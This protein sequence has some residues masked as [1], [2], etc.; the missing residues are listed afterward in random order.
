MIPE[1]YDRIAL[2]DWMMEVLAYRVWRRARGETLFGCS[3]P[4]SKDVWYAKLVE[5]LLLTVGGIISPVV[6]Y[7]NE[8]PEGGDTV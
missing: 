1:I 8:R 4:S 2:V 6:R 3:I 7:H 5:R